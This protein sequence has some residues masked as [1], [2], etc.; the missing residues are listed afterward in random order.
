MRVCLLNDS[1]PPAVD[2]VGKVV[3]SYAE[4]LKRHNCDAA[5]VIPKYPD[6]DYSKYPFKIIPYGSTGLFSNI[7]GYRCG[8]P[9]DKAAL[10]EIID[11]KPDILHAHFPYV[12]VLTAVRA[13]KRLHIPV[14][15]THHT[16]I[17]IDAKRVFK[18]TLFSKIATAVMVHNI[19]YC[20]ELWCVNEGT[21]AHLKSLGIDK[22]IKIMKN[23]VAFPKGKALPQKVSEETAKYNIPE[24]APVFLFVGRMVKCKGIPMILEAADMLQKQ[25]TDFRLVFVGSG[26]DEG[27]IKHL[28]KRLGLADDK[29]AAKCIFTGAIYDSERLRA[30]YTAADL[31]LLPSVYDN[32]P[33]VVKEAAA[34]A[35]ASIL[36]K[37]SCAAGDKS[38]G[39]NAILIDNTPKALCSALAEAAA[40]P[41]GVKKMGEHAMN[42]VYFS[43]EDAVAAAYSEYERIIKKYSAK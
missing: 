26:P 25:G 39:H 42:E 38:G 1:F 16:K 6:A 30:W 35:T 8:N 21:A 2:G 20:D 28:A 7:A 23:G 3:I 27:K 4:N 29:G 31:L 5:V 36:I 40:D 10:R 12:S 34:C 14:V 43:Q 18:L 24:R 15:Y 33:L 32:D 9:Y 17:D 11:F 13:R 19:R 37:G 41:E 22:E